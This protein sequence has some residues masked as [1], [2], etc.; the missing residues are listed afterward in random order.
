M[1]YKEKYN[2]ALERAKVAYKDEDMHLKVTLER[3]FPELQ[4]MENSENK[5]ISK[6]ITQFLKQNNGWNREWLTWLE[7]QI[8]KKSQGKSAL[9]T[10]KEGK[11]DNKNCVKSVD[12]I[13]PKF[14]EG[15]YIVP[16]DITFPET[17]RVINID[18]D[19]YYNIKCITNPEY[20]EIYR[21]PG[22]ILEEDYHIWSLDDAKD[23]DVLATWAGT[24]I[25]NGYNDGMGC[26]GCYC[27]INTLGI[28]QIGGKI[29]WTGKK[30]YPATKE[31]R[32][33]LF[34]KM[35]E[36]GYKWDAENKCLYQ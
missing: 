28:F 21:I 24:F 3:I 15:D 18:K 12:K 13:E 30:V 25:Y 33:T 20:D 35:K 10:I 32:D 19:N 7:K 16:N 1:D 17:W 5:R 11:V 2:T 27:G 26:P 34:A 14:K 9:E 23:G 29:H 4:E 36:L 6:E 8:E 22:F 31:Q